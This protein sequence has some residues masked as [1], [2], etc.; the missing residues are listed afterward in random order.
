MIAGGAREGMVLLDD[1]L[2]E[3]YQSGVVDAASVVTRI[4]D[5]EKLR[6]VTR[7]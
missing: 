1:S 2:V 5:R 4:Q 6:R 3:L 7:E